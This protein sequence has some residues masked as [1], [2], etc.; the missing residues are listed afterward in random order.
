[1]MRAAYLSILLLVLSVAAAA[2]TATVTGTVRDANGKPVEL[3]A[4]RL[5][6]AA[7]GTNSDP[8]GH[9][10]LEVPAGRRITILY[11]Y[12]GSDVVRQYMTLTAGETRTID[13]VLK[14]R[15]REI[16]EVVKRG[17]R[18]NNEAGSVYI[19]DPTHANEGAFTVDPIS[20]VIKSLVGSRNEL[21]S[22]YSV[23][24]GNF[25]ENLVYVNDFE[26]MR[27]FLVRSGQQEG[28]GFVNS[29]L[30]SNVNFSLGGFQAR[31]GDKMSSVLD[32]TYKRPKKFAGTAMASLLGA[33]LSLEGASKNEKF[34]YLFGARQKSNQYLLSAQQ[35]K[36]VY[37]PSFTDIQAVLNYRFNPRW[38]I[39]AI[40]NYAR[41]RFSLIPEE[42][43]TTFGVIDQAYQLRVFYNGS[44]I[45]QFDTRFA[46]LSVTHRPSQKLRLKLLASGFQTHEVET[47]D[48]SGEYLLGALETDLGKESFGQIKYAIGTG[49]IQ[50]YARNNLDVNV[51][52]IA[53][54][55]SY[56]AGKHTIL[57][58]VDAQFTDI[59][60]KIHEWERRDSAGF[61]Q[62]FDPNATLVMKHYLDS[63]ADFSY[64]RYS[65]FLQDNFRIGSDT[66]HVNI[67]AGVRFLESDLNQEFVV[68]PRL[69]ATYKPLWKRDV[70]F[71][72]AAG[73]YVQ[74]PFYR[75]MRDYDGVINKDLKSQ[76]SLHI[77]AG[78]E[79]NFLW[80]GRPIKLT[81]EA[82]YKKLT[83]L[84][85]Y[86]YDDV[87][88]RYSGKNDAVG[89]A[90][91]AEL[92]LY[93]ELVKDATSWMSIGV[94]NTQEDITDDKVV[95]KGVAGNDS[96]TIYPG[97]GPRPTDQRFMFGLFLQDYL[98]HNKNF[99]VNLNLMYASGLPFYQPNAPRYG[100]LLRLPDYKRADIGFS[101]LLLDAARKQRPRYSF[102]SNLESIWAGLEVFNLLGIQ[103]TLS[104]TYIQDQTSGKTFA[105][106]NH[107]TS[108]LLNV[109]LIVRF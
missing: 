16:T 88:I 23:R 109:K 106:P 78:T 54:R 65:G 47:F 30:V 71:K 93:G 84:V 96:A 14:V 103:N 85:P 64:V 31:Y 104:Y 13:V 43:T 95:Y 66:N 49:I 38:E 21:T 73:M 92:R 3:A 90:Y 101:A 40:G 63:K 82:Y 67:S 46:G 79:H 102:F 29:D 94:M 51:G 42:S 81:T 35:T 100:T 69:Q 107:L 6:D 25:D 76:K 99:R 87:R 12:V 45:D 36:G 27:P 98:P 15:T 52:T 41:N 24:G 80:A 74:P 89:Y 75:E 37:N 59:S 7:T 8:K 34:T 9:Y 53:H 108:R 28:L 22:Q 105:V 2:Q 97:Y 18:S 1:M 77:V 86:V 83:D 58:G 4:I 32:V 61:N 91:G 55:G 50:N 44:E 56:E 26:I 11:S 68:S 5:L 19:L 33:S 60:D 17:S 72:L 62:P 57:W 10:K 48:I 20:G 39:E 70:L